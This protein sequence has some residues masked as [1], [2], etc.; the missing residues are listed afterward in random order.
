M[1]IKCRYS[2]IV[3][4]SSS[5]FK[6][7]PAVDDLHPIFRVPRRTLLAK[8]KNYGTGKYDIHEERLLF[9]AL[10][11]STDA[12][13]FEHPANPKHSLIR[14]NMEGL[15][16]L[17]AW[18]DEVAPGTIKLP[19]FRVTEHSYTL[20]SIGSFIRSW[21][22]VRKEYFAPAARKAQL[23][24]LEAREYMIHK[25]INSPHKKI[26][27]YASRLIAWALPAAE[28]YDPDLIEEYTA[29]YTLKGDAIFNADLDELIGMR[30]TLQ[31]GLLTPGSHAS[32]AGLS[33]TLQ[34]L[35]YAEKLVKTRAEGKYAAIIGNDPANSFTLLS[36]SYA[37][38][39]DT[40]DLEQEENLILAQMK[41]MGMPEA[42]PNK[43]LYPSS[44]GMKWMMD[45]SAWRLTRQLR[46][47]LIALRAKKAKILSLQ[48][49][50]NQ[51]KAQDDDNE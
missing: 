6:D 11:N 8:S 45:M 38:I 5:A 44:Q 40:V 39:S 49:Q 37:Q 43:M 32:G 23:E 41:E 34:V 33:I 46:E 29:L 20:E 7:D 48:N 19:T 30:N 51:P 3:F 16:R 17:V 22:E 35:H 14:R 4:F 1:K 15:F 28:I 2:G 36:S 12:V 13:T 25:L 10:L 18:Y 27:N 31:K 47:D 42:E 24:H 50:Q 21:Y 9:L 26:E